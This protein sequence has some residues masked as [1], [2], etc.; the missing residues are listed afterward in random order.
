MLFT[1]HKWPKMIM[2][3]LWPYAMCTANEI[4]ISTLTMLQNKTQQEL[5]SRVNITPKVQ[6]FHTF[7]C[8]TYVPDNSLQVQHSIPK[9][10]KRAWMGVYLG[11]S[12]NHSRPIHLILNPRMGHISPQ[13]HVIHDD[14]FETVGEKES[15]FDSPTANW[16]HLSSFIKMPSR[17]GSMPEGGKLSLPVRE[18]QSIPL[19]DDN[20]NNTTYHLENEQLSETE[21]AN[22]KETP[23]DISEEP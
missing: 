20:H 14:F 15:N 6:H 7:G 3:N 21:A 18:D 11:P 10:N 13:Y 5:F 8:P 23:T 1:A 16:K 4:M 2:M 19:H 9:W 17:K 22:S 12:P